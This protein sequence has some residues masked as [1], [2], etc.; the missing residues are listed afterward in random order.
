VQSSLGTF[1]SDLATANFLMLI[2][3]TLVSL[4]GYYLAIR[5]TIALRIAVGGDWLILFNRRFQPVSQFTKMGS[6]VVQTAS[7]PAKNASF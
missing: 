4:D 7:S 3:H 1:A 5:S 6:I 2:G